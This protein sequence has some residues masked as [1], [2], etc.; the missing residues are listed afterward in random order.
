MVAVEVAAV[1]AETVAATAV[2]MVAAEVVVMVAAEV[3]AIN[4]FLYICSNIINNHSAQLF[5]CQI[6]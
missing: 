1:A 6:Q 3:V 5:L 2:V 4:R